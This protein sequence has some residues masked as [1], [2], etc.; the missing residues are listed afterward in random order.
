[1]INLS[2]LLWS[3]PGGGEWILILL[4]IVLLFGATKIPQLM[5]GIGQGIKEF[6]KASKQEDN[7]DEVPQKKNNQLDEKNN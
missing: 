6:K 2:I 4:A 7:E 3:M 5:K 1:M